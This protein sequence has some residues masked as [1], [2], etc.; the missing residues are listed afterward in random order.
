M[1]K[2]TVTFVFKT[3]AVV[4]I[5]TKTQLT[6]KFFHEVCVERWSLSKLQMTYMYN[7]NEI[8]IINDDDV[9]TFVELDLHT[10]NVSAVSANSI[11][12]TVGSHKEILQNY[13]A[14][15]KEKNLLS[16]DQA[17][18]LNAS[19]NPDA[20]RSKS[21][22]NNFVSKVL[23]SSSQKLSLGIYD[24]ESSIP[25]NCELAFVP[26]KGLVKFSKGVPAAV[27]IAMQERVSKNLE[28]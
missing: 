8:S 17:D 1:S 28:R 18:W 24:S 4:K 7:N 10:V 20:G 3:S 15:L 12:T 26:G 11:T 6:F 16:S 23:L 27:F 13:I 9:T 14:A 22:E 21:N 25:E 2:K 19:T 5:L